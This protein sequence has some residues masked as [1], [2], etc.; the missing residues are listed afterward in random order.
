MGRRRSDGVSKVCSQCINECKQPSY[1][2][3]IQCRYFKSAK[4]EK[5]LPSRREIIAVVKNKGH[6]VGK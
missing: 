6:V 3:V 2:E 1:M 5:P 4:T